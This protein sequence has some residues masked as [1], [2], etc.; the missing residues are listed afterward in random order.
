LP[1]RRRIAL[2]FL[3]L[4]AVALGAALFAVSAANR[5]NAEREAQRQL[6]GGASRRR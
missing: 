5:S 4:L 2:T 1:L 6:A 3:L